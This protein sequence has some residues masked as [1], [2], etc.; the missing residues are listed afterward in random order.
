MRFLLRI[1]LSF[2]LVAVAV[3]VLASIRSKFLRWD[4]DVRLLCAVTDY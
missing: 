4:R 3:V 1:A 2:S